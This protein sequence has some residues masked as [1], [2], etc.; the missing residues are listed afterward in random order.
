MLASYHNHSSWSDGKGSLEEMIES[1]RAQGVEELGVSDHFVLHPDGK[2]YPWS[3]H[4]DQLGAYVDEILELARTAPLTVRLGLEVDWFPNIAEAIRHALEP[5]PFDYLIGSVH[6]VNGFIVDGSPQA[7]ERL[8]AAERDEIHRQYW[9]NLGTMAESGLFDIAAHLDLCKK[10]AF[11]PTIDL[12]VEIAAALDAIA[13]AGLVVE[14]NTAG[15]YKPCNDAYPALAL[16]EQCHERNVPVTLSSDSH[17]PE[18]LVRDFDRGA[19]RLREAGYEQLT[20]FAGR[21]RRQEVL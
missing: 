15:W 4:P 12:S 7:W 16:L 6:E 9:L 17:R 2:Q 18:D 5:Y 3:I 19:A 13:S 10:F 20:R 1:A 8:T 21:R 11:H 14:L